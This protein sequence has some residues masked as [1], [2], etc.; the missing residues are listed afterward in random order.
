METLG[1]FGLDPVLFIAQLV[2]FLIIAYVLYR[3]LLK[4]MLA[5]LKT[6]GE[7]IAKGLQDAE[8]ARRA[9]KDAE[10]EREKIIGSAH[11]E[12][13]RIL[14]LTRTEGQRLRA[15]SVEKAREEAERVIEESR[16][17]IALERREA[18]RAVQGLA[19]ELSARIL[20]QVV[21]SLFTPEEKARIMARGLE[22]IRRLR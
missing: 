8:E 5:N 6:R 4:P 17:R 10:K 20:D 3:F 9:L 22:Q 18:E 11:T 14:E 16:G 7:K 13:A 1:R 21:A 19:L 2:N 12:A 15:E